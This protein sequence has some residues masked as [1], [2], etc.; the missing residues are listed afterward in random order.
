MAL[1]T[2]TLAQRLGL[3]N[4]PHRMVQDSLALEF[5][6]ASIRVVGLIANSAKV[7][8]VARSGRMPGS[9]SSTLFS[10]SLVRSPHGLVNGSPVSFL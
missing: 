7:I 4:S 6:E 9:A 10:I 1:R 5:R 8:K 3:L 2:Q